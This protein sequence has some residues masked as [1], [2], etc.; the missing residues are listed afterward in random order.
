MVII[1]HNK[2]NFNIFK[3]ANTNPK[4]FLGNRNGNYLL[5]SEIPQS[6]YEGFFYFNNFKMFKII[7]SIELPEA[8]AIT[9]IDNN[10]TDITR[11]RGI[12][13]ERFLP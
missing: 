9:E 6:R 1:N 3:D 5:L 10:F 2:D 12:V 8:G 13:K 4:I 7:E 11:R